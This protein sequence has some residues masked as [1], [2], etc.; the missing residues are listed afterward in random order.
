MAP[1]CPRGSA[2]PRQRHRVPDRRVHHAHRARHVHHDRR[3]PA[4]LG[5]R[6]L[7]AVLEI[8]QAAEVVVAEVLPTLAARW[9]REKVLD[10]FTLVW[11]FVTI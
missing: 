1:V 10:V 6:L 3:A 7:T 11:A 9:L 2:Q 5:C 8:E 4:L